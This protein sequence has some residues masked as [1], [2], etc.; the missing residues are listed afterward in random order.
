MNNE[1]ERALEAARRIAEA[2]DPYEAIDNMQGEEIEAMARALLSSPGGDGM[3]K[4]L[5]PF[6]NV[7][8]SSLYSD[9]DDEGYKA[10][11][12]HSATRDFT[13]QDVLRARAARDASPSECAVRRAAKM[14]LRYDGGEGSECYHAMKLFDARQALRA[15]LDASPPLDPW[16]PIAT[17]PKDGKPILARCQPAYVETGKHMPFDYQAV[18]WWRGHRFKDSQWKWRIHHND[19]AAEPTH[20]MPLPAPPSVDGRQGSGE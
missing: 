5:E 18:V 7:V 8:L 15:A 2:T 1:R 10:F 9:T 4:A 3:R 6:A 12:D 19:S 20:W 16:Q 11:L 13:R 17:A 14:L